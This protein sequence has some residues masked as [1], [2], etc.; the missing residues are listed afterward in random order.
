M[1]GSDK[2]VYFQCLFWC[3]ESF[4]FATWTLSGDF[5]AV[6][7]AAVEDAGGAMD[8]QVFFDSDFSSPP[9]EGVGWAGFH[10]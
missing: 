6:V 5:D 2:A 4:C 1:L 9:V 8:A 10:A 3:A 7:Y